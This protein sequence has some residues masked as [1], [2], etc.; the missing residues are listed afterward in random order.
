VIRPSKC[1][2]LVVLTASSLAA[3]GAAGPAGAAETLKSSLNG[4]NEVPR[5]DRDGRGTA[6]ITTDRGRGRVC[7]RIELSRVGTVGAGHIHKGSR[8]KAGGIVVTLFTK[9]TRRPSGCARGVSKALIRDIER[10]PGRY[11][12]NV[13]NQRHPAGAVRGQL[14]R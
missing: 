7:F 13:H 6:R 3:F 4:A 10:N 2:V 1:T 12:V 8:G 14:R 9:P 5:G 11:Y